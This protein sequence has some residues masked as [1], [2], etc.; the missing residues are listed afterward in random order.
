[1]AEVYGVDESRNLAS[2]KVKYEFEFEIDD[3]TD[4][5]EGRYRAIRTFTAEELEKLKDLDCKVV[6]E[7]TV[8]S[9]DGFLGDGYY[10]REFKGIDKVYTHLDASGMNYI[11]Y[12]FNAYTQ[13]VSVDAS[14]PS[15]NVEIQN[16]SIASGTENHFWFWIDILGGLPYQPSLKVKFVFEGYPN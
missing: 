9:N 13:Y 6:F 3:Q 1:M 14:T 11:A 5:E 12:T 7:E 10:L 2:P 4:T 8:S 15:G 16:F